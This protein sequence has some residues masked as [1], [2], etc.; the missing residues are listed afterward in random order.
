[1]ETHCLMSIDPLHYRVLD[2]SRKHKLGHLSSNLTAVGIL[3]EIYSTKRPQDI[4]VLSQG[5][6]GLALYVALEK[7]E[8][9]DAETLYLKHGTHPN[10]DIGDGI[11]VS[12]G[13]LG[14]AVTIALGMAMADP[15]KDVYCLISDGEAW[16]GS[17][18]EVL[19]LKNKLK[20]TNLKIHLNLNFFSCVESTETPSTVYCAKWGASMMRDELVDEIHNTEYIYDR[21]P[22]LRGVE[23]HYHQ[24]T[25]ADWA[26]VEANR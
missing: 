15:S 18:S 17:V 14:C 20:L 6:A 12:A 10:R 21:Y 16:E 8:G 19:N 5:H 7:H 2:I 26:W 4:V 24:L 11:H 23:A 13:S 3:D 22:F 1:M 25:D 9:R